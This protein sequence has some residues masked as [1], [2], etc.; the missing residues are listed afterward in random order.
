M[1]ASNTADRVRAFTTPYE[2]NFG[3]S[4]AKAELIR[5]ILELAD[6]VSCVKCEEIRCAVGDIGKAKADC[7]PLIAG[8]LVFL[9]VNGMNNVGED[10]VE[11]CANLMG[12]I[13]RNQK[14]IEVEVCSD[15]LI[16]GRLSEKRRE[17]VL[18]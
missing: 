18:N 5:R 7:A 11:D 15:A 3:K 13:F 10:C 14:A 4:I 17:P 9:K 1:L 6:T 16:W 12:W 2:A 8:D